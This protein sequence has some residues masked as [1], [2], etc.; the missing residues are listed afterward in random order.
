MSKYVN[1]AAPLFENGPSYGREDATALVLRELRE[2]MNRLSGTGLNLLVLSEGVESIGM[3]MEDA[4]SPDKPGAFLNLYMDFAR[5][6]KCHVAGSLKLKKRDRIYNSAVFIDDKG[7]FAGSY[8]KTF[9]TIGEIEQG[10]TPGN[11]AEIFDTKLGRL[12]GAI[13]FDLNFAE[14]RNQ[15]I[16]LKPDILVFPSMYHG[17]LMQQTWAYEC[18]SFF[19]SALQFPGGGILDPF[20]QALALTDCYNGI[21]RAKINLDRIM[22]HLDFNSGKFPEIQRKYGEEVRIDVPANIGPALIYSESDKRTATDIAEEFKLELL[23]DYLE[24]SSSANS[25]RRNEKD[26]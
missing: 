23:E 19:V 3:K 17:G 8:S 24:R 11:G 7:D 14:L 18:R 1:I 2:K 15:Y 6:E 9:L 5:R 13:C 20:G 10:L 25:E 12:G 21:A 16:S 4:E 26:K 22:V